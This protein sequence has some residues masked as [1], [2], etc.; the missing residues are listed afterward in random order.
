[1]SWFRHRPPKYP[2]ERP[3]EPEP[4]TFWPPENE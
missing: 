4:D 1:M 2:P 3:K